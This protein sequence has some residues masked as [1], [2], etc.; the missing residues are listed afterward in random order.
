M[1]LSSLQITLS[2]PQ[3]IRSQSSGEVV[4]PELFDKRGQA[5]EGGLYCPTIFGSDEKDRFGHIELA[6]PFI[7]PWFSFAVAACLDVASAELEE[8][9]EHRKYWVEEI[10]KP[11]KASYAL[12]VGGLLS[13][14]ELVRAEKILGEDS[15]R[16][17]TSI[18]AIQER[19]KRLDTESLHQE[20]REEFSQAVTKAKREK[21]SHRLEVIEAMLGAKQSPQ[22]LLLEVIPVMPLIYRPDEVKP[23]KVRIFEVEEDNETIEEEKSLTNLYQ[24][25]LQRNNRLKRLQDLKAPAIIILNESIVLRDCIK[26]LFSK[27]RS[28]FLINP[29]EK[30]VDFSGHAVAVVDPT[31]QLSQCGVPISMALTL[32][33]PFLF[34]RLFAEGL[35]ESFDE[36]IE[37]IELEPEAM[38]ILQELMYERPTLLFRI[39]GVEKL[40]ML[41]LTPVLVQDEALH[42]HPLLA[43]F[44]SLHLEGERLGVHVLF[45]KKAKEEVQKKLGIEENLISGI[46]R[47]FAWELSREALVGLFYL[48]HQQSEPRSPKVFASMEEALFVYE[49]GLLSLHESIR[50]KY[51]QQIFVTTPGRLLVAESAP[52]EVPFEFINQAQDKKT[53]FFVLQTWADCADPPQT[54]SFLSALETLGVHYATKAGLS[55]C[56]ED[57]LVPPSK[58]Q[59]LQGAQALI[60]EVMEQYF[61]GLITDGE[62]FNKIV[63]NNTKA[64]QRLYQEVNEQLAQS[65]NHLWLQIQ[66]TNETL[67]QELSAA[68]GQFVFNLDED[69]KGSP[70][71]TPAPESFREGL[72]SVSYFYAARKVRLKTALIEQTKE[73]SKALQATILQATKDVAIIEDDC[74]TDG[75]LE[76]VRPRHTEK[77][78][79]ASRIVGRVLARDLLSW[80]APRY[81]T[82]E[83]AD[84][85]EA[86]GAQSVYVRSPFTCESQAGVC[87]ACYGETHQKKVGF[88][89]SQAILA[90]KASQ[91]KPNSPTST[92]LARRGG[93]LRFEELRTLTN[94]NG[95]KIVV[96]RRGSYQILNEAQQIVDQQDLPYG[97]LLFVE[98]QAQ[99]AAQQ[100]I[101]EWDAF[102]LRIIA[103]EPGEAYYQNLTLYQTY[104]EEID[105]LT[106]LSQQVVIESL[107]GERPILHI[108]EPSTKKVLATYPLMTGALLVAYEYASVSVGDVLVKILKSTDSTQYKKTVEDLLEAKKPAVSALIAYMDGQISFGRFSYTNKT[109]KLT[110]SNGV[111]M[112]YT[113]PPGQHW[114][115][116]DGEQVFAGDKLCNGDDDPHEMLKVFGANHTAR[117]LVKEIQE[118]FEAHEVPLAAQHIEVI[119]RQMLRYCRIKDKGDTRFIE[120]DIVTQ[121]ELETEN[122]LVMSQDKMPAVTEAVLLGVSEVARLKTGK[123]ERLFS[124]TNYRVLAKEFLGGLKIDVNERRENI[125]LGLSIF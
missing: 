7:H 9:L 109:L 92:A 86:A 108:R 16:V 49:Q 103:E 15:F 48:T 70:Q 59:I 58:E 88:F 19:L 118:I 10:L 67:P 60:N 105:C 84:N 102:F 61:E 90:L 34:Q 23:S 17:S 8:I 66:A 116:Q 52:K 100:K 21:L 75:G 91:A 94:S 104:R 24:R 11:Q 87:A 99:V 106:G 14:E 95:E 18:E 122:E 63:E 115:V 40:S 13:E 82:K 32:W 78:S 69:G 4:R 53:I 41:S 123:L 26:E 3:Q 83:L 51:Q 42:L 2:N 35:A 71:E 47:Q 119:A 81:I 6:S 38:D 29:L 46:S 39:P 73:Q 45:S 12:S 33:R 76:M 28:S 20:L 124:E 43:Q 101:A 31:L 50:L 77:A 80:K 125:Y 107:S 89:A 98:D 114:L 85:I 1:K 37:Y 30:T 111:E 74:G 120:G 79:L 5:I 64:Y 113:L 96:S 36:A 93:T 65:K 121:R 54:K 22:D 44:L 97:A 112:E 27:I 56:I 110:A 55:L 57:F 25:V 72:G 117:Y 62:R 68:F